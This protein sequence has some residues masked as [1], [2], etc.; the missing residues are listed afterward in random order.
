MTELDWLKQESGLTDDE[1]KAWETTLGDA[2]FKTF[3]T[4]I[5]KA[6]EAEGAAR[7]KAETELQQFTQRYE[8]EFVPAMRQVTQ[9]SL[10]KE[11]EA[12]ALRAELAK[13][14][15][16]GIVPEDDKKDGKK[17]VP[18]APGSPD[19]NL[20]SR[21]DFGRF[22]AAQAN[23][24]VALQNLSAEH[25]ALFG[26]PL[27]GVDELVTEV[28]RQHTLGNKSFTL[29]NA[30]ETKHNVAAKRQ[31]VQAAAQKKHDDEIRAAAIR[32]EREKNGA[33]PNLR[34]GRTSRFSTYKSSDAQGD[35]K[36]WQSPRGARERNT[37][38]RENARVKLR[39]ATAA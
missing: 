26:S 13:A 29:K 15:E 33:N 23:T 31:E 6:N 34:S 16:Y 12:A 5:M 8:N 24:V 27:G 36:P 1:L 17:E 9:D 39:E 2:K 25:F 11:G 30:W 14:R 28:N 4:K 35:K 22:S 38:W 3:L 18:R 7:K 21:D 19:P 20:V 32:E 10:K 37:P